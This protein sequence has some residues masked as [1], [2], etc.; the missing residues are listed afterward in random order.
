MSKHMTHPSLSAPAKVVYFVGW[1]DPRPKHRFAAFLRFTND[2]GAYQELGL[3]DPAARA[4]I[5]KSLEKWLIKQDWRVL[6]SAVSIPGG[7]SA[8]EPIAYLDLPVILWPSAET[9]I[10]MKSPL[11]RGPGGGYAA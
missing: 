8:T 1:I 2:S 3:H 10:E 6:E 9:L 7:I 11:G 5:A 4:A